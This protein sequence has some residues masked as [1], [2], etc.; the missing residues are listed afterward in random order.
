MPC[1]TTLGECLPY[2]PAPR[3]PMMSTH[4]MTGAVNLSSSRN[5][6]LTAMAINRPLK[7]ESRA[8]GGETN[9]DEVKY[10]TRESLSNNV[11]VFK[12]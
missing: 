10:K 4:T 1:K 11:E 6:I 7:G 3:T 9:R 5:N 8:G 12:Y 2:A